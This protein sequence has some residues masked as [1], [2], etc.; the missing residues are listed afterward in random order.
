MI[1]WQGLS[2]DRSEMSEDDYAGFITGFGRIIG[3]LGMDLR[4]WKVVVARANSRGMSHVPA[5]LAVDSGDLTM[6]S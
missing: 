2:G 4:R 5:I 6:R 3:I 1:G